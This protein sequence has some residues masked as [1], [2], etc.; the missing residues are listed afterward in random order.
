MLLNGRL[1]VLWRS[2]GRGARR[3]L[4]DERARRA[5]SRRDRGG[6]VPGAAERLRPCLPACRRRAR[7]GRLPVPRGARGGGLGDRSPRADVE[8]LEREL[9]ETIARIREGD[10]RPTPSPFACSGCPA[11]DRVCAGP[12]LG[13][14]PRRAAAPRADVG[15]IASA[16]CASRRSTTST[17]TCRR[18]R[19]CSPT[20][21]RTESTRSSSAATSSGGRAGRV[22]RSPSRRRATLRRRELRARR[23]A[24]DERGRPLVLRPH[25]R[26]HPLVRPLVAADDRARR[27]IRSAASSSATRRPGTSSEIV[28]MLT[29]DEAVRGSARG[30]RRRRRR[31]RAHARPARPERDGCSTA[32]QRRQRRPAVRGR[33]GRV[34]GAPRHGAVE[35]GA[36]A[37]DVEP[38]LERPRRHRVPVLRRRLFARPF[39]D[40]SAP[41]RRAPMFER[42]RGA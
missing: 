29:P 28:T 11:L 42:R 5:R 36:R 4:Q 38:A 22:P 14:L 7:R 8:M 6:R 27:S 23:P 24:A 37:Y 41:S 20:S 39:A 21:R 12:D 33:D 25:R 10:F 13:A 9:R 34:L 1:D 19:R 15:G 30:G 16:R 2:D 35:P 18:S 26:R 17:A 40:S 32:R 31:L 3:R